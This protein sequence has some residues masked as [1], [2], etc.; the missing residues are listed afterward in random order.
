MRF[1]HSTRRGR[2]RYA[3]QNL[4][5]LKRSGLAQSRVLALGYCKET[6]IYFNRPVQVRPPLD[7]DKIGPGSTGTSLDASLDQQLQL[8]SAQLIFDSPQVSACERF[9]KAGVD[10][11]ENRGG[12]RVFDINK[13]LRKLTI[14]EGLGDERAREEEVAASEKGGE[15]VS[16]AHIETLAVS[17]TPPSADSKIGRQ[18]LNLTNNA[19]KHR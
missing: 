3:T 18:K 7:K 2:R 19:A 17:K 15:N 8:N 5:G 1:H 12:T 16:R 11:D 6:N 14:D 13:H 4:D 9:A 10:C